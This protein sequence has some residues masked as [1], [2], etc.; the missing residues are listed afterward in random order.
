MEQ[1]K[2]MIMLYYISLT[3]RLSELLF[4]LSM[5]MIQKKCQI[6]QKRIFNLFDSCIIPSSRE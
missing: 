1:N 4:R 2:N 5:D 3:L 6:Y